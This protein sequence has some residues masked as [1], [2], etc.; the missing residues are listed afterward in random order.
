MDGRA[1]ARPSIP[2]HRLSSTLSS[3][4]DTKA[5]MRQRAIE[6][7][8]A[9]DDGFTLIEVIVALLV[10]AIISTGVLAGMTT[11]VRMTADNRARVTA[12]NLA[13]QELDTTR[14][15][16]DTYTVQ[17][18]PSR[19]V[20]VDGRVFHLTRTV[21]WISSTGSSVSCNSSTNLFLLHVN[22]RVTWDGMVATTTGVQDDT[23]LAPADGSTNSALGAIAVSV[24]GFS[25]QPVSGVAVSVTVASG[26][27]GETPATPKP[28]TA[29]GCTYAN[30]V[31]PGNYV[32]KISKPGY[33]DPS[34]EASP[35][36]TV[37]VVA[38]STSSVE[39]V[40]DQAGAVAVKYV[41][42]PVAS[43]AVPK[44][45]PVNF[46][47]GGS[48]STVTGLGA[49]LFPSTSAY[50]VT[51][52]TAESGGA[53][54]AAI[55]PQ[56]WVGARVGGVSLRAGLTSTVNAVLGLT[57]RVEV[58]LGVVLVNVPAGST[59]T[60]IQAAPRGLGNPGCDVRS[61]LSWSVA[62]SGTWVALALPYGTWTISADGV[63]LVAGAQQVLTNA[64]PGGVS[65]DGTITL[66]P[67]T[68]S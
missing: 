48:T 43:A 14:A 56:S 3:R 21:T 13:S 63:P 15:I 6:G 8:S 20:R 34:G 40:Y 39:F 31:K 50:S 36:Q 16:A 32:V 12:A 38:G 60:A 51:A 7:P 44:N 30:G 47:A 37:S 19:E 59:L 2:L 53:T 52:G 18:A 25:G 67:R 22:V 23:I 65:T 45:L 11:I 66:D 10:F 49:A 41:F 26:S 24:V 62:G 35:Q 1:P 54:C 4:I 9:S 27:P 61:R 5:D 57:S 55:D 42:G 64:L 17:S 28:S 68:I 29:D 33:R 58:P 46:T